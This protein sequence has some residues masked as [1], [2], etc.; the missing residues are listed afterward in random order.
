MPPKD[1]SSIQN[2]I[3]PIKTTDPALD[4]IKPETTGNDVSSNTLKTIRTYASDMAT[5]IKQKQGSVMK[6]A[7]AEK[8]RR[9]E[10]ALAKN[11]VSRKN[12][13]FTFGAILLLV[14]GGVALYF[15]VL[16]KKAPKITEDAPVQNTGA[17]V[18]G[19]IQK[20]E[21]VSKAIMQ[22][23]MQ[24]L[25]NSGGHELGS[26]TL[27]SFVAPESPNGLTTENFITT[28]GIDMSAGLKRSL[29]E[30]FSL[31][32]YTLDG[33]TPFLILKSDSYDTAYIGML[34][35]EKTV[36]MDMTPLFGLPERD[37]NES[38]FGTASFVD[39]VIA[40]QDVRAIKNVANEYIFFYRVRDD[41]TII[42]TTD[43]SAFKALI[44][45]VQ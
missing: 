42:M 19:T 4:A 39:S 34:A 25:I 26:A 15:G 45:L 2:S 1:F 7:L 9:D 10:D 33:N 32:I 20:V 17:F 12:I 41:G 38:V 28:N 43:P 18:E 37:S 31:G 11:P 8:E 21:G 35:T 23:S 6:I 13:V 29:D 44:T 24:D 40:N 36:Y 5:A 14:L 3:D 30:I 16:A 22:Q 27:L